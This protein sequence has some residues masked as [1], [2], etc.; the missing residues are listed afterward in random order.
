MTDKV[1]ENV[2]AD[3]TV[4][5]KLN[6][7]TPQKMPSVYAHHL[8]VQNEETEITL[9]FFE[10]ISPIVP[11]E[12]QEKIIEMLKEV[13][14]NAECVAR[15]KIAKERLPAFAKAM[16]SVADEILKELEEIKEDADNKPNNSES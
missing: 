13:G 6:F 14:L 1:A 2:Q 11:A 3:E 10:V 8:F 9:S 5:L 7:R 4:Q 16:K 15:I 12:R